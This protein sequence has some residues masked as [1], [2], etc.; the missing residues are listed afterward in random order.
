MSAQRILRTQQGNV[1]AVFRAGRFRNRAGCPCGWDGPL[2]MLLGWAVVDA[3]THGG[4]S[5]GCLPSAPLIVD[6]RRAR[7][8]LRAVWRR[9]TPWWAV[10]GLAMAAAVVGLMLTPP[11][12]HAAPPGCEQIAWGF[13]GSQ[14]RLI[15]DGPIRPDGSWERS[16]V[17]GVPAHYRNARSSCSSGTYYSDC[18]FYPAGWV[19]QVTVEDTSYI[20]FPWNVLPNEPGHLG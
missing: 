1:I 4:R 13:L 20:V 15:C 14:Q 6:E 11:E 17:I 9:L 19:E 5:A 18:T 8:S 16:R 12:V 7:P 2:R 3:Y 10:T